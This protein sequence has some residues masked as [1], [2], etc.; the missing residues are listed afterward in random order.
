MH[1]SPLCTATLDLGR[2]GAAHCIGQISTLKMPCVALGP[3][4]TQ[5]FSSL[6]CQ[7]GC[8]ASIAKYKPA[9]VICKPQK[10]EGRSQSAHYSQCP[11]NPTWHINLHLPRPC[12]CARNR[13]V[14]DRSTSEP[15]SSFSAQ[16]GPQRLLPPR[17][18]VRDRQCLSKGT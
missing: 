14:V 12:P 16:S 15:G 5:Y 8:N 10:H 3:N 2:Q 1:L 13:Q 18:R 7:W 4:A 6:K 17:M 9:V 11:E